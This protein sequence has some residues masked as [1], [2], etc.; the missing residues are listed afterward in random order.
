[1]DGARPSRRAVL[2]E[3][4]KTKSR[5]DA[6]AELA[7]LRRTGGKRADNYEPKE[8]ER[9]YDEVDDAEYAEHVKKKREEGGALAIAA[10]QGLPRGLG[11]VQIDTEWWWTTPPEFKSDPFSV[12]SLVRRRFRRRRRRPRVR[13]HRRGGGL[14]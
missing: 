13:R 3:K 5:A 2:Q 14:G 10:R 11:S 4:P 9:V 1:M 6:L 7:T 8:E 12:F